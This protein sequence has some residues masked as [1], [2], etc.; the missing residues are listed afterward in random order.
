MNYL[1]HMYLSCS[2]EDL[3]VGNML[4][5]MLPIKRLRAL[6][7][8][9]EQGFELHRLIDSYTDS[10]DEVR[11]AVER[12][13]PNHGKYSSVVIDI[14]YDYVLSQEWARYSGED[15]QEF[16]NTVY[17]ILPKHYDHLPEDIVVRFTNMIKGNYLMT[18]S[19]APLLQSVFERVGGRAR[20]LNSFAT[21]TE[22]LLEDYEFY[23]DNFNAFF[24]DMIAQA[25]QFCDC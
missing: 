11:A 22:D 20:F 25:M 5:D 17:T 4:V 3:L 13:R 14:F 23:R 24:P 6:P 7:K 1:A 10:H 15:L 2:D 8:Q 18:C 19:T 21:A 16:C 9:Y 12:L